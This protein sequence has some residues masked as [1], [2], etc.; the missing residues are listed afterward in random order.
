[1]ERG[2]EKSKK[3]RK[4]VFFF[5]PPFE[6]QPGLGF[7]EHPVGGGQTHEVHHHLDRGR[8]VVRPLQ[9]LDFAGWKLQGW[10]GH[11]PGN[12]RTWRY[13]VSYGPA[14]GQNT[15]Q[16]ANRLKELDPKWFTLKKVDEFLF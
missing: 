16:Q 7:R 6:D 11:E 9:R 1:M 8:G 5:F 10:I 13:K 3:V 15:A 2:V 14:V 12:L 4:P